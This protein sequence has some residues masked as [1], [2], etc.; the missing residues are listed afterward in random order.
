MAFTN[1]IRF[2]DEAGS[3]WYGDIPEE[4]LDRI[5]GSQVPILEGDLFED[6]LVS[7][8]QTAVV[9]QVLCPLEKVPLILCIGLNY[10]RHAQEANL[11]I[12]PSPVLFIKPPAALAGPFDDI[13]VPPHAL[14]L[15]YEGE[16]C[17]II[18]KDGKDISEAEADDY[19]LGCTAG[20]D[21]SSRYWQRPPHSGGQYCYAKGFDGFAPIGPTIRATQKTDMSNLRLETTVN[22]EQ[23]QSTITSD[24]LFNPRQ[25]VSHLSRGYTLSKGTVIMTGTPDGIAGRMPGQPWLQNKDVVRVS[26]SGVGSIENRIISP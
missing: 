13:K 5:V 18:K 1:L 15:D 23:R 14:H 26:I 8:G 20:N 12:P 4:F 21:V 17:L 22:G 9:Q 2:R 6:T 7:N 24:V 19:I 25:I 3:I 16:L 10:A 11:P